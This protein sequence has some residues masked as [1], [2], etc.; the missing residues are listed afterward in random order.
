MGEHIP[1]QFEHTFI[2]NIVNHATTGI[3][4]SWAVVGQRG[5]DT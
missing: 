2:S 4:L 1:R 5:T 3:V